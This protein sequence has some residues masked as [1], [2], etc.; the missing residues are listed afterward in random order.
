M[1]RV[2]KSLRELFKATLIVRSENYE[3]AFFILLAVDI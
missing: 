2:C 3:S 1:L